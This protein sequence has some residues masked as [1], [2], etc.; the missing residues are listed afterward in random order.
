[1]EGVRRV[2]WPGVELHEQRARFLA[3]PKTKTQLGLE[4]APLDP[5]LQR[6]RLEY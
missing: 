1:L 6:L 4:Q 2:E 3:F 5:R